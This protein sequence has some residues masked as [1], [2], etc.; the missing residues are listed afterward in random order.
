[1]SQLTEQLVRSSSGVGGMTQASTGERRSWQQIREQAKRRVPALQ[2][3]TG[4]GTVGLLGDAD[5]ELVELIYACTIGGVPFSVLQPIARAESDNAYTKRLRRNLADA[6]CA[7]AVCTSSARSL[8]A[9]PEMILM[10][11][12]NAATKTQTA[13]MSQPLDD[14][15]LVKHFSS[16]TTGTAR[17]VPLT[18]ANVLAGCNSTMNASDHAAIHQALLSWLPLSHD[19]G[20]F[21]FL[22]IAMLCGDCELVVDSPTRFVNDPRTWFTDIAHYKATTIAA[23]NFAYAL[24]S[25]LLRAGKAPDLSSLRCCLTGGERVTRASMMGFERAGAAAGLAANT[26]LVAYGLAEATLAVTMTTPGSPLTYITDAT[27][28]NER[29]IVS[30]GYPVPGVDIDISG[31]KPDGHIL[32]RGEG[33][34]AEISDEHGWLSTG[35]LGRIVDG[36]VVVTGREKN[37]IIRGGQNFYSEDFEAVA[38]ELTFVRAG[39]VAA[40]PLYNEVTGTEDVVLFIEVD[41]ELLHSVELR[42]AVRQHIHRAIGVAVDNVQFVPR[43]SIPKTSSGKIQHKLLMDSHLA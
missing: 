13:K 34:C 9:G 28:A 3:A 41:A 43:H 27:H 38:T 6:N 19:M 32:V 22:F 26:Q 29:Q 1:M 12:L 15:V 21:G 42:A 10:A 35:D 4:L 16:G 37:L 8:L 25:R 40:A 14:D 31:E 11:D 20:L 23:P 24:G 17:C 39:A 5:F 18:H 36:Q 30:C 2:R 7:F 33:V